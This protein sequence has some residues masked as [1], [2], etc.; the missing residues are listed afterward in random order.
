MKCISL[1][2]PW[3]SAVAMGLKRY[4]TRSW[5]CPPSLIGKPL[6]IHAAK[7]DTDE[8]L[9]RWLAHEFLAETD[10]ELAKDIKEWP[11]DAGRA[12]ATYDALPRGAVVCIT[13]VVQ[14]WRTDD[15]VTTPDMLTTEERAWGDYTPGR[16][17]WQLEMIYRF[18]DAPA[19]VGRQGLFDWSVPEE[20]MAAELKRAGLPA[21]LLDIWR[22][23]KP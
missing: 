3:A 18:E 1:W 9:R 13:K 22:A 12:M 19:C 10:E 14:C 8:Q 2:Q 21:G 17:A 20:W 15:L 6:A 5:A 23:V 16:Y 7:R 4:E 11:Y